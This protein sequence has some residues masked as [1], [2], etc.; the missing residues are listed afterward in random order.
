MVH[1]LGLGGG[2]DR[3]ECF[4]PQWMIQRPSNKLMRL[5]RVLYREFIMR[6]KIF[7]RRNKPVD[8]FYGGSQWWS[9]TGEMIDWIKKFVRNNEEYYSYFKHGV[10]VD[11]IFFSTLVRYSPYKDYI[12]NNHMRF[13]KW[14]EP[15]NSSGGPGI[16]MKK[17][18]YNMIDSPYAFARKFT[19]IETI[20]KLENILT[21]SS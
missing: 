21:K 20:K 1:L 14:D 17:D 13:M 6:T 8:K 3:F 10:C 7:K 2:K 15:G 18:I 16:L 5:I 9:L 19:D 12:E 11:E 4:Y